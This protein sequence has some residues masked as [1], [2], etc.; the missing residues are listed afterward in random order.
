[1]NHE[2]GPTHHRGS[3]LTAPAQV[4]TYSNIVT[5]GLQALWLA[6]VLAGRVEPPPAAAMEQDV[7]EQQVWKREVMP[8][9]RNRGSVLMTYQTHY[10]DQASSAF[11]ASVCA[12][13]SWC[14]SHTRRGFVLVLLVVAVP[15]H[16]RPAP[17]FNSRS[18]HPP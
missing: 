18:L 17:A 8:V 16:A 7:R 15:L 14:H 13:V 2:S 3:P 11:L 1:M 12:H 10:H 4:S 6:H 5:Q 9:Q